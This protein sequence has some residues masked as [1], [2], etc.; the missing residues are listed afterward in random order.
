MEAIQETTN[1]S[2]ISADR[3][4][5]RTINN[6]NYFIL[7]KPKEESNQFGRFDRAMTMNWANYCR[8]YLLFGG[9]L[10]PSA[11]RSLQCI[12]DVAMI[13][14]HSTMNC[15]NFRRTSQKIMARNE[16]WSKIIISCLKSEF[17]I[18]LNLPKSRLSKWI[19]KLRYI[20]M[21]LWRQRSPRTVLLRLMQCRAE[22]A[23]SLVRLIF[24][25]WVVLCSCDAHQRFKVQMNFWMKKSG[26]MPNYFSEHW[27]SMHD[28]ACSSRCA[29]DCDSI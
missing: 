1:G 16:T 15:Q 17:K 10:F 8:I 5:E 3:R 12:F 2:C 18:E 9:A 11:H 28:M 13:A 7:C 21:R 24:L 6:N 23:L 22:R 20:K 29:Q 27:L 14:L 25:A 4:R 19:R 26:K